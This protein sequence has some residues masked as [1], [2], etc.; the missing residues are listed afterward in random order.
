MKMINNIEIFDTITKSQLLIVD[1]S[2]ENLDALNIILR[3]ENYDVIIA[4]NGYAALKLLDTYTPD[5][6]LL[7]IEMPKMNGFELCRRIKQNNKFTDTPVIFITGKHLTDDIVEGFNV[8]G[9]D[10]L[11]KPFNLKELLLRIK[12]HLDLK[13]SRELIMQNSRKIEEYNKE[14]VAINERLIELNA[15]KDRFLNVLRSDLQSAADYVSTLMPDPISNEPIKV[16]WEFHPSS[17]LSGDSF[18]YHWIDDCF[19]FYLI[20]VSGHGVKSAL[21]SVSVL[22]ILR[23]ESLRKTDF[24]KP[25]QVLKGLDKVFRIKEPDFLYF[26]IW[27]GCYSTSTK[28]LIYAG[29][30]HP[31]AVLNQNGSIRMLRSKNKLIAGFDGVKFVS[32]RVKIKTPATLYIYSD[33]AYEV[34]K[35]D[36]KMCTFGEMIDY[37]TDNANDDD[38]ELSMLYD[39]IRSINAREKMRDDFSVMKITIRE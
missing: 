23:S 18:G 8:G 17:Q 11:V 29:A 39:H 12:T 24:T 33:G 15:A 4:D 13:F 19:V 30:G 32:N 26:S 28:Y 16:S 3:K 6:F 21:Q 25:N 36:G 14:L 27:Y 31:P 2:R 35:E 7:D 5:I 22:N 20:D 37:L 10:Y 1:D 34:K 9:V 38:S